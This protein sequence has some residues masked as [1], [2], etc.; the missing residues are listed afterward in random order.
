MNLQYT[1]LFNNTGR[2]QEEEKGKRDIEDTEK[3][4]YNIKEISVKPAK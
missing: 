1:A 4:I 2:T 3:T